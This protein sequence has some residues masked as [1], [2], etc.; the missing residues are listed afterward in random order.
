ML[1]E[2]IEKYNL[3]GAKYEPNPNCKFCHGT[4]EKFIKRRNDYSF[5]ICLYIDP[6]HSD[7]IGDMLK[8]FAVN[9]LKEMEN[10]ET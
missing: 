7:E 3:K 6:N 9:K 8:E 4:G 1:K 5:C 2:L 10:N